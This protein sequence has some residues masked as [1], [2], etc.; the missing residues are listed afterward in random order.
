MWYLV[1]WFFHIN[2]WW[3][4][5]I[6]ISNWNGRKPIKSHGMSQY[7]HDFMPIYVYRRRRRYCRLYWVGKRLSQL[8]VFDNSKFQLAA[9]VL[10]TLQRYAS[11]K[12]ENNLS[13]ATENTK[14][15]AKL[16]L[17]TD[18]NFKL[19][20]TVV[21]SLWSIRN[22]LRSLLC[23]PRTRLDLLT[24]SKLDCFGILFPIDFE[25]LE[26]PNISNEL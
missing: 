7:L 1:S 13:E 24:C 8:N 19:R 15:V 14:F 16:T 25:H 17:E 21:H 12:N 26:I 20:W 2:T 9:M 18:S 10:L 11:P 23:R 6:H 5:R 4:L 22:A 3:C